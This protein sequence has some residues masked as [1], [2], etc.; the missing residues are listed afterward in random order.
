MQPRFMEATRARGPTDPA[1]TTF[2]VSLTHKFTHSAVTGTD[3]RLVIDT[4]FIRN[5]IPGLATVF[6]RYQVVKVSV[7]APA[8]QDSFVRYSQSSSTADAGFDQAN[9]ID[10]G[11][12]GARRPSLHIIPSFAAR[13]RWLAMDDTT[14][15]AIITAL[16]DV[17]IVSQIT[18]RLRSIPQS[19]T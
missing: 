11:T 1:P 14:Q 16:P 3:G 4:P 2:D 17:L 19:Q 5:G 10:Y 18:V 15:F 8:T 13:N 9:F 6:D 12:Q 7:F